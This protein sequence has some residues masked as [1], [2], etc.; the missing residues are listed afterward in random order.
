MNTARQ[1]S[2]LISAAV[3]LAIVAASA[4]APLVAA[5]PL[6]PFQAQHHEADTA[7]YLDIAADLDAKA[8]H[9]AKMAYRYRVRSTGGSKQQAT[10][11]NLAWRYER[12]AEEHRMA[13]TRARR[14][15]ESRRLG[16]EQH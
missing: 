5:E 8:K 15:A 4:P 6:S 1:D 16:S 11:H 2:A 7:T 3:V 13:A 9:C 12:L 14:L 10:L